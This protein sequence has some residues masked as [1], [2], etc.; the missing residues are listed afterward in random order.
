MI[1]EEIKKQMKLDICYWFKENFP[2]CDIKRKPLKDIVNM[3]KHEIIHMKICRKFIEIGDIALVLNLHKK[4]Y[5]AKILSHY[6]L[7]YNLPQYYP[8]YILIEFIHYLYDMIYGIFTFRKLKYL[9]LYT[10]Y[11]IKKNLFKLKM[12]DKTK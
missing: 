4:S 8:K 3:I 7:I 11:F 6:P 5:G 12:R 1:S 9:A 2:D 10:I